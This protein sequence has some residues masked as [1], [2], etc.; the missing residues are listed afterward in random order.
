MEIEL[1][2]KIIMIKKTLGPD[3]FTACAGS[4]QG[5]PQVLWFTSRTH[6]YDSFAH[7]LYFL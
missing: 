6:N 5:Y 7:G 3:G 1:A 4:P 2:I